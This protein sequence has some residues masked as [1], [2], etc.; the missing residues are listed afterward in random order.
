MSLTSVTP[1][2]VVFAPRAAQI[3]A[4]STLASTPATS[5]TTTAAGAVQTGQGGSSEVSGGRAGT[6]ADAA[7]GCEEVVSGGGMLDICRQLTAPDF[8]P[9]G[10]DGVTDSDAAL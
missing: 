10:S 8:V 1:D 7:T 5:P 4:T 9:D 6:G 2:E 3:P